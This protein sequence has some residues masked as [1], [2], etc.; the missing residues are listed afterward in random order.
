[1]TKPLAW[2][3]VGLLVASAFTAGATGPDRSPQMEGGDNESAPP[4]GF[5]SSVVGMEEAAVDGTVAV[6]RFETRFAAA[7][8]DAERAAVVAA[9]LNETRDRV[10]T[11]EMRLATLEARRTNG[12]ISRGWFE[13][14]TSWLLASAENQD[15][16][17]A[18]L[19]RAARR[20]PP[21]SLRRHNAS[22][23]RIRI[24]RARTDE[25]LARERPDIHRTSF[26]RQFYREVAAF[27][28]RFNESARAGES[29]TVERF[30]DSERVTF[31][32]ESPGGPPAV[33]SFRTTD[34]GRIVDLRAGARPD[35]TVRFRTDARTA[36]RLFAAE[37]PRA[38]FARALLDGDVTAR[39]VGPGN[40]FKWGVR[41]GVLRGVRAVRDLQEGIAGVV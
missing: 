6:A 14:E 27:A 20:L 26:D 31:V 9:T 29:G 25:L 13:V 3:L 11:L 37:N 5:V 41:T 38:A 39:G 17:L 21:A 12:T 2:A 28:D 32:V 23:A 10:A 8:T 33:V 18:R 4:G 16:V 22:V 34:D 30:L 7:E 1:M 19:E 40:R 15:R 24:V 35:A 36:R